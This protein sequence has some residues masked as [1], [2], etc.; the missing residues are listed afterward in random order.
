MTYQMVVVLFFLLP[1]GTIFAYA[2]SQ[3]IEGL[4]KAVETLGKM[5]EDINVRL[6][7][8]VGGDGRGDDDVPNG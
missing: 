3:A 8:G 2:V 7:D 1:V 6:A 5:V 4:I